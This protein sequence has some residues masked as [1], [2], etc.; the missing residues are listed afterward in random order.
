MCKM[1]CFQAFGCV[2]PSFLVKLQDPE[3]EKKNQILRAEGQNAK[4]L[5]SA[6]TGSWPFPLHN[7]PVTQLE[8]SAFYI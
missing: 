2:N 4:E 3:E 1:A 6:F 8:A 5:T 7:Q